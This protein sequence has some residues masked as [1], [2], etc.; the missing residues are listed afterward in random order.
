[1][2]GIESKEAGVTPVKSDAPLAA[3]L[4]M[5]GGGMMCDSESCSF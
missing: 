3:L 1:M 5:L 4:P 2:T